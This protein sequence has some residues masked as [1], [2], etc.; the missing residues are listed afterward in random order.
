MKA[1]F[2]EKIFSFDGKIFFSLLFCDS[3]AYNQKCEGSCL[4]C[5]TADAYPF[6]ARSARLHLGSAL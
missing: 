6:P 3:F 2:V 1:K 5:F 4:Y